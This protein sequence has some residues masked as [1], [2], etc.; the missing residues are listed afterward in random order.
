MAGR[1]EV[2]IVPTSVFE[3][4]SFNRSANYA[5]TDNGWSPFAPESFQISFQE[6]KVAVAHSAFGLI[7]NSNLPI[8][9]LAVYPSGAPGDIDICLGSPPL[10][11]EGS[12]KSLFFESS[13]FSESGESLLR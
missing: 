3:F 9:G 10:P 12:E 8:P 13:Y 5:S 7:L 6:L 4:L 11:D 2:P 1:R